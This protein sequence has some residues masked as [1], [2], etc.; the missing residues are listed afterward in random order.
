MRNRFC[1]DIV[2]DIQ[3]KSGVELKIFGSEDAVEGLG[4]IV[5][6]ADYSEVLQSPSYNGYAAVYRNGNIYFC[7]RDATLAIKAVKKLLSNI[8]IKDHVTKDADGKATLKIPTELFFE[9]QPDYPIK[10][11]KLLGKPISYFRLVYPVRNVSAMLV[12]K[13]LVRTIGEQTG[14]VVECVSDSSPRREGEILLGNTN[15][16]AFSMDTSIDCYGYSVKSKNGDIYVEWGSP[17]AADAAVDMLISSIGSKEI[18]V[19]G[20]ADDRVSIKREDGQ[21]RVMSS[22]VLFTVN[23]DTVLSFTERADLHSE[24]YLM[25]MPDFIGLQE[26]MGGIGD[27]IVDNLEDEYTRISQCGHRMTPILYRHSIW[28]PVTDNG[29]L[30]S[31]YLDFKPN[32]CWGYEWVLFE[33]ISDGQRVIIMNMH[34]QPTDLTPETKEQRPLAL[35]DTN[36]ELK[37]LIIEYENIPIFLSGDYNMGVETDD[38]AALFEGVNMASG[39]LL[40]EDND[41]NGKAGHHFD[42]PIQWGDPYVI[43]HVCVTVDSVSVVRHRRFEYYAILFASDHYPMFI[44]VTLKTAS[45]Q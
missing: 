18:F 13:Q 38:Y 32:Y 21:I 8:T 33:R 20:N 16:G 17:Y 43:D 29:V 6:G 40:T 4:A 7:G 24:M 2:A 12:A 39:M 31:G 45:V 19:D 30:V 26:A 37:R 9:Y 14:F 5:L 27:R 41:N 22:N 10:D 44:D 36:A 11:A 28:R 34:V 3:R 15:R 35:A 23:T 25:F 1:S 42:S